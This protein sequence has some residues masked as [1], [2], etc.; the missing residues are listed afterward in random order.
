MNEQD[1]SPT[2]APA[3][4]EAEHPPGGAARAK[5]TNPVLIVVGVV[6]AVMVVLVVLLATSG[7]DDEAPDT[8]AEVLDDAAP[9]LV[10]ETISGESFA[11]SDL[12]GDWVVVNFFATW[13][14]PCVAEH[15]ELAAFEASNEFDAKV[16]SVAFD[17]PAEKV[18]AFF[19]EHGGDWP[20]VAQ[21]DQIPL[22]W[23]VLGLPESFLVSP[24]GE[25]VEKYEG[26]VTAAGLEEDIRAHS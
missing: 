19:A 5:G 6:A 4:P 9:P 25:V 22:E 14:P 18:A 8:A 15:P 24:E 1:P 3:A 20:V 10:G 23:S 26:Q 7:G 13:C 2:D 16:V 21:S 17:E 11:L 12:E